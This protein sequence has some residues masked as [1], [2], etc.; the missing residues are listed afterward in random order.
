LKIKNEYAVNTL[1]FIDEQVELLTQDIDEN[2][3]SVEKFRVRKGI[4]DLSVEAT[5]YLESVK[6]FD[7]KISEL[8]VQISFLN[9]LEGYVSQGKELSGNI[10]PGSV[11]VNDPLLTNLILK[12]E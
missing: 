11:L 1:R 3:A 9:Y 5:S 10:S 2:E 4:T 6:Q 12:N 7:A 8:Q